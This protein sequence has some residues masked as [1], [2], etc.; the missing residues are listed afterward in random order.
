MAKSNKTK[1]VRN[2][3][4]E[5]RKLFGAWTVNN[6]LLSKLPLLLVLLTVGT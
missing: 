2:A 3:Q 1:P 4:Q 6:F 5:T